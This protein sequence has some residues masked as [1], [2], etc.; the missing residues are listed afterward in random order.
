MQRNLRIRGRFRDFGTYRFASVHD[1]FYEPLL[2]M[3]RA[4]GVIRPR[5][6]L[7]GISGVRGECRFEAARS[8]G[9]SGQ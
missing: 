3:E 7:Q 1:D 8:S 9:V 4:E 6:D 2:I 5:D